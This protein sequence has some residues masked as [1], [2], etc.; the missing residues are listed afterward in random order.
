MEINKK[1]QELEKEYKTLEKKLADKELF[2]NVDKAKETTKRYSEL[3]PIIAHKKELEKLKTDIEKIKT[4]LGESDDLELTELLNTELKEKETKKETVQ[5]RLVQ[6]LSFGDGSDNNYNKII[7]EIRA[8]AGGQE[9]S[10]FAF[11][12]FQMYT[13]FAEKYGWDVKIVSDNKTDLGGYKE[14]VLE[15]TGKDA[16]KLLKFESGVHR[17]QRIPQTEKSGRVHTSTAAVAIIPVVSE[18][19]L[20][21]NPNDFEISTFRA[22][23]PGGQNV[24]KVE[25]AVRVTHKPSGLVVS[26]QTERSQVKNKERALEIMRS[27]LFQIKKEQEQEKKGELRKEQIGRMMRAEKIRTYNFPQ[28]RITDHRLKKNWHNINSILSGNL[29][30]ILKTLSKITE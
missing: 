25:T 22:S 29:E 12:L 28:D 11:E 30:P 4:A 8:G 2:S 16:Y 15:L 24:N 17:V 19:T 7:V 14:V 3:Q 21:I 27:K 5:A 23:G 9:A 10:L 6:E 1:L 18:K 13:N 26:S 20:K